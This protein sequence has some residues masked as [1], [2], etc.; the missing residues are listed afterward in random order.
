M[1]HILKIKKEN[2]GMCGH[3]EPYGN[4]GCHG[5]RGGR[6][7]EKADD[8]CRKNKEHM[9]R[10]EGCCNHEH[11]VGQRFQ[12]RFVTKEEQITWLEGYLKDIQTEAKAVEEQIA[13]LKK[14]A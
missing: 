2:K 5:E 13:E 6:G 3:N 4:H 10:G 8:C 14:I 7:D 1:N 9:W 12:R 11:G